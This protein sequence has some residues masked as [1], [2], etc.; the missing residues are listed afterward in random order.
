MRAILKAARIGSTLALI[1]AAPS[2]M[3]LSSAPQ[4]G[5]AAVVFNPSLERRDVMLRLANSGADLVRFGAAPGVVVIDLP[6]EGPAA[7][8]SAGA[9]LVL[10]PVMLGGCAPGDADTLS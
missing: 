5:Q 4:S 8:R 1:A 9:W 6:E 2:V 10:D 3:A 7:M